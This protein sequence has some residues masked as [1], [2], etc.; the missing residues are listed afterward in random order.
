MT[1]TGSSHALGRVAVSD[2]YSLP[3][4]PDK[5]IRQDMSMFVWQRLGDIDSRLGSLLEKHGRLDEQLGERYG[6]LN[7]KLGEVQ[8]VVKDT[9]ERV[10]KIEDTVK[11]VHG[12]FLAT[13]VV[14]AAGWAIFQFIIPHLR[15][16]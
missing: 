7:E 5:E 8:L 3:S 15:W 14:I 9:S 4:V 16:I 1:A 13:G 10:E 12:I 6:R 2:D 11:I